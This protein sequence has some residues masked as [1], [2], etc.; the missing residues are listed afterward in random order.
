MQLEDSELASR[1]QNGDMGAFNQIVERYQRQVFGLTARILGNP[2]SAEDATQETF[3]SAYRAIGKFKGGSLRAWLFRIASNNCYDVLRSSKRRPEQSLDES[4]ENPM[5]QV[6]SADP[7]PEQ[8]AL[9]GELGEYIQT[10]ILAL[11]PD[12]RTVLVMIDVQGM[13]YEETSQATGAS[14]GTVK[15]RLS[16]ARG[17]VREHLKQNVELLP[18]QFRH[19]DRGT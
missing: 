3:I 17:R 12:Q 14:I 1:S 8:L 13:S 5:F 7:T 2:A 9:R 10:A 19:I 6:E 4:M 16:R 11:A 18:D 15:S